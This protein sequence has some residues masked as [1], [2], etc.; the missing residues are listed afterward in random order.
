MVHVHR[1]QKLAV[2]QMRQPKLFTRNTGKL[3]HMR[4]PG[5]NVRV[6][7]RP[8]HADAFLEVRLKIQITQ[9]VTLPAPHYG[10]S[11]HDVR[12]VPV[13]ALLLSVQCVAIAHPVLLGHFVVR[14]IAREFWM[15]IDL[16]QRELP[17]VLR[18][19]GSLHC[20]LITRDML[21]LPTT[22]QH[23]YPQAFLGELLCSPAP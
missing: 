2:R 3:L 14:I 1:R 11:S 10:L 23:Q 6:A 21:E 4:I 13:E 12:P 5:R 9:P 15:R 22:L 20:V 17:P 16:L 7:N 19:P 8:V 18:L